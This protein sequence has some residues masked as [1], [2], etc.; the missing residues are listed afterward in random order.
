MHK[1]H[2][3]I[4]WILIILFKGTIKLQECSLHSLLNVVFTGIEVK[5]LQQQNWMWESLKYL[6]IF[7]TV[8]LMSLEMAMI[9]VVTKYGTK[10]T[11][12]ERPG[13]IIP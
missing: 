2:Y 3:S 10:P 4:D 11:H 9:T 8:S 6:L 1:Y 7:V 12:R 5:D 13:H